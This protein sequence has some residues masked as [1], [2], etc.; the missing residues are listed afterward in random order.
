MRNFLTIFSLN[1]TALLVACSCIFVSA[2]QT[3]V[4]LSEKKMEVDALEAAGISTNINQI[5]EVNLFFE[6]YSEEIDDFSDDVDYLKI[7]KTCC[8]NGDHEAGVAA[9]TARNKKIETM[10][11]DME[12]FSY[13]DLLELSRIITSECG[14][15]WLPMTW[16]MAVGEVV[17]NRVNSPEFPNTIK[18]VI[19][20]PGQYANA[21]T[22]RFY[23]LVPF[24]DCVNA[25]GRL[26][27]GQ[28]VLDNPSVV[29]QS[30]CVQGSGVYLQ[31]YDSVFGYTYLCYSSYPELYGG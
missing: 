6:N 27:S 24:E 7:M 2:K 14:S 8:M 10:S 30:G 29:F 26:L 16:K 3:D 12:K 23:N 17:L 28:R 25:A 1:F 11:L 13:E 21:N 18:E 15:S 5:E 20:Q 19:H 4:N 22:S 31:L 9:E